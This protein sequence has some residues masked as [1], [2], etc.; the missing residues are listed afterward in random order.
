MGEIALQERRQRRL[1]EGGELERGLTCIYNNYE[2]EFQRAIA[3]WGPC[4]CSLPIA[5][6]CWM[7]VLLHSETK[8]AVPKN[9]GCVT[10]GSVKNLVLEFKILF[11][12]LLTSSLPQMLATPGEDGSLQ[13]KPSPMCSHMS[14]RN[15]AT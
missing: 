10:V 8:E 12:C 4:D 15:P 14:G 6:R 5:G 11:L 13:R 9:M 7:L 3:G 1:S 2:S